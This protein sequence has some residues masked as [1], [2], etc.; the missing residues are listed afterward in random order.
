M[1]T[2][3]VKQMLQKMG[4]S[5]HCP[6]LLSENASGRFP[7]LKIQKESVIGIADFWENAYNI[8]VAFF[9]VS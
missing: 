7:F 8:S 4:R 5:V 1:Q 3:V 9:R 2:L 6:F